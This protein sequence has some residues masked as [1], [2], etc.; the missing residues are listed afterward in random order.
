MN[1]LRN[2][3]VSLLIRHAESWLSYSDSLTKFCHV[4][5]AEM[6]VHTSVCATGSDVQDPA[7]FCLFSFSRLGTESSEQ[8]PENTTMPII[9]SAGIAKSRI[10]LAIARKTALSHP[11]RPAILS[12]VPRAERVSWEGASG[13]GVDWDEL[14]VIWLLV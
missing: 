11:I 13:S 5:H 12:V 9:S 3:V 7:S 1:P 14:L 10:G 6:A 2:F 8:R 4:Q